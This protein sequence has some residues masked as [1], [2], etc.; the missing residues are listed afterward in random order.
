[1][2]LLR[3]V[4]AAAAVVALAFVGLVAYGSARWREAG[5]A[6][7]ARLQ[8]S[9]APV[10]PPRHDAG[11]FEALPAPVQRYLRRAL[12]ADAAPIVSV[13][14]TQEGEFDLGGE[15]ARWRPFVATQQVQ[16]ARPGFVWHARVFLLPGV[17]VQVH[18]AY[19]AGEGLLHAALLGLWSVAEL[20]GAGGIAD[21]E[22]M[23]W[24][25]ESPWYPSALLPGQGVHWQAVDE[26]RARASVRDR[27]REATLEFEFGSDD[28]VAAVRAPARGRMVGARLVAT[29]W[30]GRWS[31]YEE[32][33]GMLIPQAGEVAWLLPGGRRPYWRGTLGRIDY[34]FAP[35]AR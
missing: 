28:L 13:Q 21:D 31:R 19:V 10:A 23:R 3:T 14:F 12:R 11:Q 20:R 2:S 29:P 9:A 17:A 26:R 27:A 1:M 25:A 24:L 18:D 22:L 16:I 15:R 6:L 30:E 8:A 7:A 4:L 35:Q 34:G 5:A 33:S 32:R